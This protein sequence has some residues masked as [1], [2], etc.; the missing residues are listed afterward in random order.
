MRRRDFLTVL[1]SAAAWPFVAMAQQGERV[2][3]VG[4]LPV[5]DDA[6]GSSFSAQLSMLR[7]ELVK[8]G[9]AEGRNLR[10][11]VRFGA[12]D[13][14]RIRAFAAELVGLAPDAIVTSG[15]APTRAVQRQ[16]Q[17]IPI[18]IL[19]AGDVFAS[20]YVKDVAH[21]EGNTTGISNLFHSI[22]SKWV[23]LLKEA[24]PQLK[25]VGYV[26]NAQVAGLGSYFPYI[27]EASRVLT[28]PVTAISFR[29]AVDLVHGIEAFAAEPDGGL[30]T[31]PSVS[32]TFI[33]TINTL[34]VQNR[35]PTLYASG[36]G[37]AIQGG[38]MSYGSRVEELTRRGASLV[39]RILRGAKVSDLPVEFPTKF[40]LVVNLKTAKAIG[41]KIPEGF[42]LRADELIE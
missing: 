14:D 40:E 25:R 33:Q 18:V 29:N 4:I 30:I 26:Y 22:G 5:G 37:S 11:E 41:L 42:L 13:E 34:A 6:P 35:L 32:V 16:T 39:D 38:L 21:P 28:V 10:L 20:G 7:A 1:G 19:G 8:L 2:R 12:N 24:V 17:T 36:Q 23:E 3:R 9:W 31:A 27:E 15:A